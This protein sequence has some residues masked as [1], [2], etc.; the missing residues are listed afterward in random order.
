ML[1]AP[2][3]STAPGAGGDRLSAASNALIAR[4]HRALPARSAAGNN[5]A[6]HEREAGEN[7][8]A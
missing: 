2:T 7:R 8:F 4:S 5:A 3:N 1:D 6:D